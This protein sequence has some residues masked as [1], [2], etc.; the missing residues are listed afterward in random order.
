MEKTRGASEIT[1]LTKESIEGQS[2][3]STQHH[4]KKR[5]SKS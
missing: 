1:R 2:L 5:K 3:L 4:S